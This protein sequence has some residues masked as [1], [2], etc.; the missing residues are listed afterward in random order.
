MRHWCNKTVNS[1]DR[2]KRL[3]YTLRFVFGEPP[4]NLAPQRSHFFIWNRAPRNELQFGHLQLSS[5]NTNTP[6]KNRINAIVIPPSPRKD[7]R[8]EDERSRYNKT[9]GIHAIST[10]N[11]FFLRFSNSFITVFM[12]ISLCPLQ[13]IKIDSMVNVSYAPHGCFDG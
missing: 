13:A 12:L 9:A 1:K 10:I 4:C 11:C 5:V 6:N 7:T 2:S 8:P 3:R